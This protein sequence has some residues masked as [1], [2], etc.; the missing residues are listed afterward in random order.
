MLRRRRRGQSHR[1][2]GVVFARQRLA[3][4][5]AVVLWVV[6]PLATRPLGPEPE[7]SP[8][9]VLGV[10]LAAL[11]FAIVPILG[12][13]ALNRRH[14]PRLRAHGAERERSGCT[15]QSRV[16]GQSRLEE[17]RRGGAFHSSCAARRSSAW[18]PPARNIW[19]SSSG[20]Y[21]LKGSSSGILA[22]EENG[23]AHD[24]S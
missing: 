24:R 21:R 10:V 15:S 8:L 22:R 16:G 14:H 2:D 13:D 11:P 23:L 20:V 17:A 5:A 1:V 19:V 4:H 7:A 6:V 12:V 18:A 3:A 9:A